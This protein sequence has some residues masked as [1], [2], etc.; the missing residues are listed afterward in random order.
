MKTPLQQFL[1]KKSFESFLQE[2]HAK[3]YH[4]CDDDMPDA[5][6]AW[7]SEIEG[8]EMQQYAEMWGEELVLETI[9][10]VEG[11]VL[12]S[13]DS[14]D[15]VTGFEVSVREALSRLREESNQKEI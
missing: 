3:V 15:E 6:D 9:A 14:G 12:E 10:F 13:Q 8:D 4:G 5:F 7:V 1:G 2:K 11:E